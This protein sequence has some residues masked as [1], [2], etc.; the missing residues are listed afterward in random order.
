[1]RFTGSFPTIRTHGVPGRAASSPSSSSTVSGT[2][3]CSTS[4][5]VAFMRVRSLGAHVLGDPGQQA[6]DEAAGVLRGVL[7][8]ELDGLGDRDR[9]RGLGNPTELVRADAE[10]RAVDHR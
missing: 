7:L 5:D 4:G 6:V 1:M 8:G 2:T 10:Q 9:G 3:I